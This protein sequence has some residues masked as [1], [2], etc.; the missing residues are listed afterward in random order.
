M[1]PEDP[2]EARDIFGKILDGRGPSRSAA[3]SDRDT[4][5]LSR[6]VPRGR[7]FTGVLRQ[8]FFGTNQAQLRAISPANQTERVGS[9]VM[10]IQ[11]DRMTALGGR[12]F[13][14]VVNQTG[15]TAVYLGLSED[16]AASLP[17][18]RTA[19]FQQIESFLNEHI[20]NYSVKLGELELK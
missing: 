15:T 20:Y 1:D 2:E 17:L 16:E 9:P 5:V 10:I 7:S 4:Q 13:A 14:T 3:S 18:A 8:D 6:T 11:A 12:S 19:L